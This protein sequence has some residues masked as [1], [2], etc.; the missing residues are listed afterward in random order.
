MALLSR[1]ARIWRTRPRSASISPSWASSSTAM[2]MPGSC[3]PVELDHLRRQLVEAEAGEL[4]LRGAGVLAEGVDHLLD[5]VD[6]L[7]DRVGRALEQPRMLGV[8]AAQ[9]L[10]PHLLGRQLDRRQR[11]LDLVREPAR[12]LAP[13]RAAL[14]VEQRRDVL[15]DDDQPGLLAV[16][17][18]RRAGPQQYARVGLEL[19]RQLFAPFALARGQARA[20]RRGEARQQAVGRG[21][22]SQALP[23]TA[24][25]VTAQDHAGRLVGAAQLQLRVDH[26]HAAR[27]ARE[28]DREALALAFHGLAA[29]RRLLAAAAQALGHVVE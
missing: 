24:C 9:Q 1:L 5:G 15:E 2:L 21:A 17:G 23:R 26:E 27:Q 18:Q 22:R 20:Q 4:H 6:L 3:E 12:D 16:V 19:E 10:A 14:R 28:D 25:E 29:Q 7:H 11:V 13:G 8:Q